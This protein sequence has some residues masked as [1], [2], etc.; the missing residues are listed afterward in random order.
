MFI[1]RYVLEYLL[2][3]DKNKCKISISRGIVQCAVTINITGCFELL[4]KMTKV[5]P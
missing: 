3:R 1:D 4:K 2:H 5:F